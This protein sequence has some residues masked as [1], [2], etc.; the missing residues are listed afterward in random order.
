MM[1]QLF[2][3]S[4]NIARMQSLP[5]PPS[6]L[7]HT[8]LHWCLL[9]YTTTRTIVIRCYWVEPIPPVLVSKLY[10][11]MS[12]MMHFTSNSVHWVLLVPGGTLWQGSQQAQL[13]R[14]CILSQIFGGSEGKFELTPHQCGKTLV[15]WSAMFTP[16]TSRGNSVTTCSSEKENTSSWQN[17]N[18]NP[19]YQSIIVYLYQLYIIKRIHSLLIICQTLSNT[20]GKGHK[21]RR[22]KLS[23]GS[24]RNAVFNSKMKS[25]EVQTQDWLKRKTEAWTYWAL[26]VS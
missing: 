22:K 19:V 24:K 7:H 4:D 9:A 8:G 1:W 25:Y 5:S 23:I 14:Y 6:N 10:V 18:Q 12:E 2:L 16:P 20:P 11:E 17:L 21:T 13:N 3:C 15:Q 26:L